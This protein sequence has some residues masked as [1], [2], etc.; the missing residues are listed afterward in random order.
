[1]TWQYRRFALPCPAGYSL[2]RSHFL[3]LP[4]A[5]SLKVLPVLQRSV[6]GY[7]AGPAE[8][9]LPGLLYPWLPESKTADWHASSITIS[10]SYGSNRSMRSSSS[11]SVTQHSHSNIATTYWQVLYLPQDS[12]SWRSCIFMRK[13]PFL[14]VPGVGVVGRSGAPDR[15]LI[16]GDR[17]PMNESQQYWWNCRDYEFINFVR[18]Y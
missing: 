18:I 12:C 11:S 17:L 2:V 8:V 7:Y 9:A 3:L 14:E 5:L 1:M 13:R 6:G 4:T 16:L 10:D 15:D